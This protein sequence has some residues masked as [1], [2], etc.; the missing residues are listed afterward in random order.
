MSIETR[1]MRKSDWGYWD[2]LDGR[3]LEEG[4]RLVVEWPDGSTTTEVCHVRKG[5]FNYNDHGHPGTGPDNVA[6]VN[7]TVRGKV[8]EVPLT[9]MPAK[10]E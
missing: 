2:E 7:A 9:G 3:A 10:R 8:V 4:E 1:V 6:F 5:V